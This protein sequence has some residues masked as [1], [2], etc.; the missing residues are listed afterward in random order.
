M[1]LTTASG[2]VKVNFQ[3]ACCDPSEICRVGIR[4]V[5]VGVPEGERNG[6]YRHGARTKEAIELR[7]L[8]PLC[9]WQ[10]PF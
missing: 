9:C 5:R 6:N 3:E 2:I 7:A 4:D 10:I 1:Y 8:I